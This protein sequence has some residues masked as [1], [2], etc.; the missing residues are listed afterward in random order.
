MNS[1]TTNEFLTPGMRVKIKKS[2]SNIRNSDGQMNP[3]FEIAYDTLMSSYDSSR[4]TLD[5]VIKFLYS[6]QHYDKELQ[7]IV[8]LYETMQKLK[9]NVSDLRWAYNLMIES[10]WSQ[11]EILQAWP[12]MDV[13]LLT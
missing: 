4:A 11:Q 5:D 2:V 9:V 6:I 1:E 12:K 13:E 10:G 8:E 3:A 7:T